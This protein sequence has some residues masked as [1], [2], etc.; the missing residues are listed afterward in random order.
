MAG[1]GAYDEGDMAD[2]IEV[3][4]PRWWLVIGV[5]P[6]VVCGLVVVFASMDSTGRILWGAMAVLFL[7]GGMAILRNRFVVDGSELKLRGVMSWKR[8][9]LARLATA[10]AEQRRGRN[11]SFWELRL[12]DHD[13]HRVRL[14]LNG[15]SRSSRV[16]L[17]QAMRH[18]V[19]ADGVVRQGPIEKALA[20]N[21]WWPR[22]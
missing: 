3:V 16:E 22:Q 18:Y 13:D 4:P 1:S 7:A 8:I 19:E 21:L 2:R 12:V 20:G 11:Y 14:R 15:I 6:A 10:S 5:G 9:D 17:L